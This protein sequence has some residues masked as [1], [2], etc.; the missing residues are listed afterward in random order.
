MVMFGKDLTDD[1]QKIYRDFYIKIKEKTL[2][3]YFVMKEL[4]RRNPVQF[5][6]KVAQMRDFDQNTLANL[7]N[8]NEIKQYQC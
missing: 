3:E 8:A 2:E 7:Q 6:V 5:R 1:T 4:Y